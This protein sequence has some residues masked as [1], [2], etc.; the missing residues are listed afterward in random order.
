MVSPTTTA[1]GRLYLGWAVAAGGERERG[2]AMMTEAFAIE[3]VSGTPEDFSIYSDMLAETLVAAGRAGTALDEVE[4][5]IAEAEERVWP[6][7]LPELHRRRGEVLLALSAPR[8]DE[9]EA[10]FGEALS[11]ARS[12][13]SLA[14]ELRAAPVS[15][16][17]GAGAVDRVARQLLGEILR[18]VPGGFR[19]PRPARR[20]ARARG[21]GRRADVAPTAGACG[22]MRRDRTLGHIDRAARSDR[23]SRLV[24]HLARMGITRVA[25]VTG[26][27]RVG[28]PVVTVVRPNARS[29]ASPRARA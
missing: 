10:C 22:L 24:P 15:P 18:P 12:Q 29:L 14:L 5:A 3:R 4:R 13:H 28:V 27:D 8:A 6:I 25:N 7:W 23:S 11:L 2:I 19:H 21:A 26:L 16:A 20:S 17:C 9:A 1:K